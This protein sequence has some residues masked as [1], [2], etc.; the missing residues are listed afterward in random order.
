MNKV[1]YNL[2]YS[3]HTFMLCLSMYVF[4]ERYYQQIL[5]ITTFSDAYFLIWGFNYS[6]LVNFC[7]HDFYRK[8]FLFVL[9]VC[10]VCWFRKLRSLK[11]ILV[12]YTALWKPIINEHKENLRTCVKSFCSFLMEVKCVFFLHSVQHYSFTL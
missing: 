8:V 12:Q 4:T 9:F 2:N 1:L 10:S 7:I 11:N 3:Y 6:N 5:A